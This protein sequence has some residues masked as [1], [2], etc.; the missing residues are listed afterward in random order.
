MEQETHRQE[1]VAEV[2]EHHHKT[3]NTCVVVEVATKHESDRNNMVGHHLPV[4][5][6]TCLRI[7]DQDLV[8]IEC[9]LGKVVELQRTSQRDM[10]IIRPHV[11]RVQDVGG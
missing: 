8:E 10:G 6:P 9:G 3:S 4:V 2:H 7:E 1:N 5:L 11:Y